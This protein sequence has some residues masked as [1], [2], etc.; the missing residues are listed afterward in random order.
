[1]LRRLTSA[2]VITITLGVAVA[3]ASAASATH[4]TATNQQRSARDAHQMLASLRLPAGATPAKQEPAG[5]HGLLRYQLTD[6]KVHRLAHGWWTL[7]E[8]PESVIDY[9]KSHPPAGSTQNMLGSSSSPSGTDLAVGFSWPPIAGI[10]NYREL[11]VTVTALA[12][13]ETGVLA[14][15]QSSWVVT[16]SPSEMV[17]AGVKGVVVTLS[18]IPATGQP[19]LHTAAI[20]NRKLVR[21]AVTLIDSLAVAQPGTFNCPAM[22]GPARQLTVTFSAGPAGPALAKAELTI[23][24]HRPSGGDSCDPIQ[25]WIRGRAQTALVGTS[26]ARKIEALAGIQGS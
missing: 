3:G 13:G 16:R 14:E 4:D 2:L 9:L 23:Y 10:L 6:E 24:A 12:D 17:P 5:D 25:F 22:I 11:N 18:R 26:F 1:L 15:A 7:G 20:T 21:R 19:P 8:R